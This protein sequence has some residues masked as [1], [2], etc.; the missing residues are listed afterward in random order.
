VS[1]TL[2][3]A[4]AHDLSQLH[5]ELLAAALVPE[6]V[7]GLGDDLVLTMP[8][9]TVEADVDAVVAAHVARAR[10]DP[11]T[12]RAEVAARRRAGGRA[13]L[14]VRAAKAATVADLRAVL[15]AHLQAEE[16]AEA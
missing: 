1:V 9:G 14:R 13:A 5:D 15:L 4:K 2:P 11:A 8:D 10:Y 3:Y 12:R 6:R 7:E 16:E